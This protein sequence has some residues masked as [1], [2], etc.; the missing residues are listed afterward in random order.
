VGAA[1]PVLS[2]VAREVWGQVVMALDAAM[3]EQVAGTGLPLGG[4]IQHA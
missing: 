3:T 2:V 4:G 1:I